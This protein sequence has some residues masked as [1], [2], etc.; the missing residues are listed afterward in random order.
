MYNF[1]KT[2][3][4]FTGNPLSCDKIETLQVNLGLKCNQKCRHCHVSASPGRQ[5]AMG[6]RTMEEVIKAAGH[7]CPQAIDLTGGAP[8]LNP[9][10]R[11]FVSRLKDCGHKLQL[12][13]NLTALLEPGLEDLPEFL[14]G[15]RVG[16]VASMPCYLEENVRAQRG[17]GVY[18]KSVRAIRK[19]NSSRYG[20]DPS[21]R[22]DLVYNPGGPFLPPSQT[23][24]EEDYR[25]ELDIRFGLVFSNLLTIT[26]MP[27]GRLLAEMKESGKESEY[28][29]LLSGSFNP[30]TIDGLMCRHQVSVGWNGTLFDCDFN[31]A[32]GLTVDES[33]P[34]NLSLVNDSNVP[35]LS[36]RR[37]VTGAHCFG[38]TA[39]CGSSCKGALV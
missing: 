30:A 7:I 31:L 2:I 34:Q 15:N 4:G 3:T 13:T 12:R 39:G 28:L 16:L 17:A 6:R 9:D 29:E 10:I 35:A 36:K 26:N 14:A 19:L 22:L 32:L 23:A 1:E 18:E 24:L 38:C 33:A 11:W 20:I 21:L 25:R 37:V 5:E 8:E 27:I